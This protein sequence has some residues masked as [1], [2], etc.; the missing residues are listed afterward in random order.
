M[1]PC[2]NV[3]NVKSEVGVIPLVNTAIL[4]PIVSP[5]ADR[6]LDSVIHYVFGKLETHARALSRMSATK[7]MSSI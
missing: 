3:F 6:A 7:S 5:L 2:H 4:T 1:L